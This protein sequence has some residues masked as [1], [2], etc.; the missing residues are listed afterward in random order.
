MPHPLSIIWISVFPE[1]LI[2]NWISFA[3]ESIEFS[4]VSFTTDAGLWITSPAAIWFAMFSGKRL[5]IS[6]L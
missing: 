2:I 6:N 5:I 1:S 4:R 3:P